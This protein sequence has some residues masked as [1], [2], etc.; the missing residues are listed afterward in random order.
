MQ[1]YPALSLY[2]A[3][4]SQMREAN[5]ARLAVEPIL[6]SAAFVQSAD[7]AKQGGPSRLFML[8]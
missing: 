2:R 6:A 3:N 1:I 7:T 8:L 4:S 5:V